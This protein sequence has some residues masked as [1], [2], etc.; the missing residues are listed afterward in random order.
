MQ[1]I[2]LA[3]LGLTMLVGLAM[4]E[5]PLE[6]ETK[7]V[8]FNYEERISGDGGFGSYNTMAAIGPHPDHRVQNKLAEVNLQK[9]S[10]G[11]GSIE[12][13]TIIN[14]TKSSIAIE[15]DIT[16]DIARVAILGNSSMVYKPQSMPI[17]NG[18]Y[19]T[20][21]VN[22]KYLLGDK[23]RIKNYASESSMVH[24][25]KQAKG[26]NMDMAAS[27]EDDFSNANN[28]ESVTNTIL[29]LNI[30][31]SSGSTHI[32]MLQGGILDRGKS[33]RHDPDIEV[34]DDYIGSFD[35]A[36][37]MNSTLPVHKST[38]VDSWLP[39]C[40][41]GWV[42]MMNSDKKDFGADANGIFDCTCLKGL[43]RV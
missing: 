9:M 5:D 7:E 3:M 15:S 22:F 30:S 27:V 24:E 23:L 40:Y 35:L 18:Y 28:P 41:S 34:D 32:G 2:I 13:E 11:S 17:G 20:N 8:L 38:D 16:Y 31:V 4:S 12:K 26:I 1:K 39:C 43:K 33:A 42:D 14:S 37:K 10:H 21:P 6:M 25:T 36:T 29:D 19:A